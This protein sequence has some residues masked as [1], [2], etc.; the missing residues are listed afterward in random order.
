MDIINDAQ[1][2]LEELKPNFEESKK[3]R[4]QVDIST[5]VCFVN[6]S[7]KFCEAAKIDLRLSKLA[8]EL[9]DLKKEVEN[10]TLS[11]S[12]FDSI[13][14]DNEKYGFMEYYD[15]EIRNLENRQTTMMQQICQIDQQQANDYQQNLFNFE[16]KYFEN[17]LKIAQKIGDASSK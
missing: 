11:L 10:A 15:K 14:K 8:N 16:K 9:K 13:F 17:Y 1:R 7:L 6:W 4:G 2:A 12:R 5:F 3:V